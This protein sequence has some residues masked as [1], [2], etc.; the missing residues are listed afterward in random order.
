MAESFPKD[1]FEDLKEQVPKTRVGFVQHF[2][3]RIEESLASGHSVKDVWE[4]A[5][6]RG[7][8]V[9]YYDFCRYLRQVR[10]RVPKRQRGAARRPKAPSVEKAVQPVESQSSQGGEHDPFANLRRAEAERMVFN[11]RGTRDL[12]E[13]VYGKRKHDKEQ[14]S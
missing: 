11:Y 14:S 10:A 4:Y 1:M 13:L 2:L 5:R 12:E 3:P 6:E 9:S 7:F 8:N